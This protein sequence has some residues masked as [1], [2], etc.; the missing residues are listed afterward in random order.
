MSGG[1]LLLKLRQDLLL[2]PLPTQKTN[3]MPVLSGY[4]I[5]HDISYLPSPS[6]DPRRTPWNPKLDAPRKTTLGNT[7]PLL[8]PRTTNTDPRRLSSDQADEAQSSSQPPK[9]ITPSTSRPPPGDVSQHNLQHNLE[10]WPP[11]PLAF[12][13]VSRRPLQHVIKI[14]PARPESPI[15]VLYNPRNGCG[16]HYSVNHAGFRRRR[17]NWN[18]WSIRLD[19]G[20][21]NA[22]S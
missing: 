19:N 3:R 4:D 16:T 14:L 9:P 12:L 2:L 1:L 21:G 10:N 6:P 7:L 15:G 18:S 17:W 8:L 13:H 22:W 20:D 5:D 11:F